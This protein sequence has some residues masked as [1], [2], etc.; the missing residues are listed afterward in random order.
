MEPAQPPRPRVAVILINRDRPDLTD[1]TFEQLQSMGAGVDK[2]LF[3]VECG[4]S[5]EGRSRYTTHSFEDKTYRGRYYGFNQGLKFAQQEGSWDYYWFVVNDIIFPEGQDTL[6]ILVDTM[7]REPRM[8]LLGPGE[9][10]ADDYQGAEPQPGREWHKA[11]TVH[12]LAWL[13]RAQAI[14]EV[15]Y[16]NPV[17]KYSQGASTELAYLLYKN[18]WFLA[19]SDRATLEHDQSGSTYGKVTKISRHEYHRR[20]R[21]FATRY[22]KRHYGERWDELFTSVLP[23]EVEHNTFPWQKAV[24]EKELPR[25]KS[26]LEQKLRGLGSALKHRLTGKGSSAKTDETEASQ[27]S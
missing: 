8:A 10:G 12:G 26:P 15:G 14:D 2:K 13:M 17:F 9:P 16:C 1:R 20:A 22:L 3:V 27:Q 11:S 24:W 19:Y 5:P 23:P 25:E 6:Q 18:G 7:A 21:K 4:S